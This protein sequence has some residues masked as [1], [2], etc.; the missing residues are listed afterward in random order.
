MA[1]LGWELNLGFAGSGAGEPAGPPEGFTMPVHRT[2]YHYNLLLM[3]LI[4]WLL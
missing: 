3:G 4:P 1:A 2:H